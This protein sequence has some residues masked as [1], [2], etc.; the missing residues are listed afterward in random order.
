M[1]PTVVYTSSVKASLVLCP[2]LGKSFR[3]IRQYLLC[4]REK[5]WE[6][7]SCKPSVI[8]FHIA[9]STHNK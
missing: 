2:F 6:Q 5:Q 1:D 8:D 9:H 7:F 3:S 4:E